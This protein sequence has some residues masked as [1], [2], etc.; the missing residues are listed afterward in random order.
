MTMFVRG[1][2]CSLDVD[3]LRLGSLGLVA[4]AFAATFTGLGRAQ[5][6][7]FEGDQAF[8][9]G[10]SSVDVKSADLDG[11]GHVDLVVL[12]SDFFSGSGSVSVLLNQGNGTF[13]LPSRY[14]VGSFPVSL[15][16]VDL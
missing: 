9:T 11:D 16:I 5:G 14:T 3:L 6:V 15:T 1:G 2:R 12:N 8:Q 10:G 4:S 7:C 13:A